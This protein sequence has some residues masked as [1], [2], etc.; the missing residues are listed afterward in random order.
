MV[1]LLQKKQISQIYWIKLEILVKKTR[2]KSDKEKQEKEI[3]SN[4][5]Y[6]FYNAKEMVLNGFK[7]KI[8][9]IKSTGTNILNTDNSKNL[10]Y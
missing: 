5:L 10:K 3:V 7:S 6:Q 2:P 8:F 4:N 1:K 9:L